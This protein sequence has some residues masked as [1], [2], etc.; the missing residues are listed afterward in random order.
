MTVTAT[1]IILLMA[2]C[3]I[4][5]LSPV[6][7]NKGEFNFTGQ[8]KSKVAFEF[9]FHRDDTYHLWP[10]VLKRAQRDPTID[11]S[12]WAIYPLEPL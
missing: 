4:T 5:L 8:D 1:I 6:K 2:S 7:I 3:W 10:Y 12:P 9:T 11:E